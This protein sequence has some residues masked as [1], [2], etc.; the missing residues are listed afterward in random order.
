MI[1]KKF[2]TFLSAFLF[3]FCLQSKQSYALTFTEFAYNNAKINNLKIIQK[4]LNRGYNI[5]TIDNKGLTALCY[6][7]EYN[8]FN[9]YENLKKLGANPNHYCTTIIETEFFQK[10]YHANTHNINNKISTA[11]Q[12]NKNL[13]LTTGL[14]TAGGAIA[15]LSGGGGGSGKSA[16]RCKAGYE[17]TNDE[18]LP[19]DCGS[20]YQ[21]SC[22]GDQFETGKTCQS[23]ETLLKECKPYTTSEG[24]IEQSSSEDKCLA[25]DNEHVLYN[26]RCYNIINCPENF[27][28][29]GQNCVAKSNLLITSQ[30]NEDIYG[31]SSKSHHVYNL[32]STYSHPDDNQKIE[33]NNSGLGKTYGMYGLRHVTNAYVSGRNSDT[34]I[35]IKPNGLGVI[36]INNTN[37]NNTESVYGIYA[38]V[39]NPQNSWEASNSYAVNYGTASGKINITNQGTG[40]TFGIFGDDRAYNAFSYNH[41]ISYGDINI[42][43]NGDIYGIGGYLAATN[44]SSFQSWPDPN[45]GGKASLGNINIKSTGDGDIYGMHVSK[46]FI[47]TEE[48]DLTAQWFI[49]NAAG[50]YQDIVEGNINITNQGSGNVHGMY[51][52]TLM[53]NGTYWGIEEGGITSKVTANINILN[54]G[55]GNVYGMYTPEKDALVINHNVTGKTDQAG[56]TSNINLINKG[57]GV[58]TG[59]R[60]GEKNNIENSG[61]IN[62]NNLGNGT[63][64][65]IYGDINSSILNKGTINIYRQEYTDPKTGKVY[66]PTS[67]IGGTAYGIYAKSGSKVT[68]TGTINISNAQ[69]GAG[70]YL[71]EGAE[72]INN[73]EIEGTITFNGVSQDAIT[74]SALDIYKEP[75]PTSV[76]NFDTM[77]KGNVVLGSSGKFFADTIKG[78]LSVT[79]TPIYGNFKNSHTLYSSLNAEDISSLN[80]KSKS[81]MFK[82]T[83]KEN[84]DNNND[85]ILTRQ[86]FNSL[87]KDKNIANFLELN[88]NDQNNLA[89]YDNLKQAK[90]TATLNAK[91]NNITGKDILPS[92]KRENAVIYHN[93]NRE[94]NNNLFNKTDENYIVGYK[95]ID[96]SNDNTENL[97]ES[98]GTANVAYGLLKSKTNSGLTYGIGANITQLKTDYDNSSTRKSNQFGLWLP[99]GYNFDNNINWY[100]KLYTGYIDNSYDRITD[101]GKKT[102]SYNEYQIGLS[103]EIRYRIALSNGLKLE[104][105]A[106]LNYL[107]S[108]QDSITENN[109][110][111]ALKI[112][113][114]NFS[115]LEL[116]LGAYLTKEFL[117]DNAQKLTI[118]I[119]GVYYVEFLDPDKALNASMKNMDYRLKIHNPK[120]N[121]HGSASLRATYNY[122]N[123]LLYGNIEKDFSSVDAFS[124]D[125]GIQYAF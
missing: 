92:F 28:Q 73:G 27:K 64:I 66:S 68:N 125:A 99:L 5:D 82:A 121:N 2:L 10:Q 11:K 53:F 19:K 44:A 32:L 95:Y 50:N 24:C 45:F 39:D 15:L 74:G 96:I 89:L 26:N 119:G 8:D 61:T 57:D 65:G 107:H 31:V 42:E 71:E 55:N 20:D 40:S 21:I 17:L 75:S 106:E 59:L 6:A 43:A 97:E 102:A 69:A 41:G 117:F 70:I 104:P 91:A 60:G 14:L 111:D 52:G 120:N 94:F 115:S 30:N 56:V 88:Y 101:F 1:N 54:E 85:V 108:Y 124:I 79:D 25:C 67:Q 29:V 83:S 7:I 72:L 105:L 110:T 38:H 46:G 98:N 22:G 13:Y 84:S 103:N 23:G 35:N 49:I 36:T 63:A 116:G 3:M 113:S 9:A 112:N 62:I 114:H 78:N 37:K 109:S 100:S 47:Q 18:C 81:A 118:Q 77:G 34:E 93:L 86:N 76:L 51:G 90:T 87:I 58:T 16:S 33:I 122:N 123:L 12:S 48:D 4:F 80:L